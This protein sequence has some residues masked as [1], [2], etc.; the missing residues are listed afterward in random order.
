MRICF[1]LDGVICTLRQEGESYSDVRPL[2]GAR[3]TMQRLRDDGHTLII[4]TA[5]HMKTCGGNVGLVLAR[6]GQVTLEW[7][8]RHDIPYDE[9]V[10][11]KPYAHVYV[12]DNGFRFTDWETLGKAGEGLPRHRETGKAAT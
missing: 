5:R 11:G 9:I 10:F 4:H 12:D 6:Q 8:A 1:D 7:L 3:E 2:P